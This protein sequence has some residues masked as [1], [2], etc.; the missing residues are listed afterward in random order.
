MASFEIKDGVAI[1]QEGTTE[2]E[3]EAFNNCTE[4]TSI[5]IPNSVTTIGAHAFRGCI[6]LKSITIP[7]SVT[8]IGFCVF[9][10]CTSLESV[11]VAEGNTMYDSR[12]GCN[13]IVRTIDNTLFY[14]YSG[15][16]RI[17]W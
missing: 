1:I 14:N 2:I 5:V 15:N 9:D 12:E 17:Y 13:A 8:T 11:V 16:Y 10:G 7:E 4:L 3:S 6:S